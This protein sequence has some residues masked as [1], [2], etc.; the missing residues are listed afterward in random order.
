MNE[1]KTDEFYQELYSAWLNY[2]SLKFKLPVSNLNKES[3]T[4]A[5]KDSNVPENI[6]KKTNQILE[7]CESARYAP[8]SNED[9]NKTLKESKSIINEIEAYAKV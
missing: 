9:S 3:I 6:I 4:N 2:L 1:N 8:I 7:E 5:F